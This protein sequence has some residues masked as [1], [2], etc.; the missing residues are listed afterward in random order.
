M[1]LGFEGG[2]GAQFQ[3]AQLHNPQNAR[4]HPN[5]VRIY[6]WCVEPPTVCII[7]ELLPCTLKH[8]LYPS[9]ASRLGRAASAGKHIP[10][11]DSGPLLPTSNTGG[12][13]SSTVA[14]LAGA[15]ITTAA[16]AA[17]GG[18]DATGGGGVTGGNA[19]AA[20]LTLATSVTVAPSPFAATSTDQA[21]GASYTPGVPAPSSASN[22]ASVPPPRSLLSTVWSGVADAAPPGALDVVLRLGV[23]IAAGLA[24]LHAPRQARGSGERSATAEPAGLAGG[25]EPPRAM[26]QGPEAPGAGAGGSSS[27]AGGAPLDRV[28]HRGELV[29]SC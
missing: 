2:C 22:S 17:G 20:P 12:Q 26:E 8:W 24:H 11:R 28:V 27:A 13:G 3:A 9:S 29:F 18:A 19:P 21:G 16:T 10:S 7:M 1:S 25:E 15:T 6:G 14:A 23:D 4:R 5:I